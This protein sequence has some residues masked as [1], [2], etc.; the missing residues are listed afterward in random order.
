[1]H[2]D[3]QCGADTEA[4]KQ[5]SRPALNSTV[6]KATAIV[7]VLALGFHALFEGIAFGLLVEIEQAG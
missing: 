2:E 5:L 4:D 3:S 7:L 1:M 6:S